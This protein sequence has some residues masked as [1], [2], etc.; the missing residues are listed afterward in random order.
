MASAM[1]TY[2]TA[3]RASEAGFVFIGRTVTDRDVEPVSVPP[4]AG[5]GVVVQVEEVL[6]GTDVTR[7]LTGQDVTV[8]TSDPDG[9]RRGGRIVFF[10]RVVSLGS[11]ALLAELA[12]R[13]TTDDAVRE[14][15]EAVAAAEE[16]PLAGRVA[17]ADLVVVGAV[18]ASRPVA[19]D[20]PPTSEHDA[21]WWIARVT[22]G[23]VVKGRTRRREVEALFANS[24]DIS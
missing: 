2:E 22:V 19:P 20:Q 13:E 8:A 4:A 23:E 11:R 16:E 6:R 10:T 12:H 3:R 14:V 5:T 15:S 7:S 17:R 21:D 24:T 9:V 1:D 18:V